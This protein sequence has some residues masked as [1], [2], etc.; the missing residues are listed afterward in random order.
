[1]RFLIIA[2]FILALL[3]QSAGLPVCTQA[4]H[5]QAKYR[6]VGPDGQSYASYHPQ[7]DPSGCAF[8]HEH[9]S[10]PAL[11]DPA[12]R[13][14]LGYS[15]SKH[16]TTE[17]HAGFKLYSFRA[18]GYS[19]L[20]LHHFGTGNAPLAACTRHHT[21]DLAVRDDTQLLASLHLMADHGRAASN[22]NGT[23]LQTAC[24]DQGT[25]PTSAGTRQFPIASGQ[26][27]GYEPWRASSLAPFVRLQNITFNT[28]DPQT[29]C[30]DLTCSA[31]VQRPGAKGA[32]RELTLYP[33]FGVVATGAYSN[34]FTYEGM[35]QHITPGLDIRL[36]QG[37][38]LYP[39]GGQSY[40]YA[41]ASPTLDAV[42]FL[43]NPFVTGAN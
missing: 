27:I 3:P 16:G 25:I 13:P 17:G 43:K 20:L 23:L 37:Y 42:P 4:I 31:A 1:M 12:Y 36:A 32:W 33:G 35:R 19:W 30:N 22:E 2:A 5:D 7:V 14:P 41:G 18:G 39:Y 10:N 29:A 28:K 34:T 11:F 24:A 8:D 21:L 26:N 6:A 40:I 38:T 15:A 9:G